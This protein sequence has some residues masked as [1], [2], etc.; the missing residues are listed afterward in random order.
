MTLKKLKLLIKIL[1]RLDFI[2]KFGLLSGLRKEEELRH[3]HM[4][5]DKLQ[6]QE[7]GGYDAV[8]LNIY[9]VHKKASLPYCL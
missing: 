1:C 4:F 2:V 5:K 3:M 8:L 7:K 6:T 9:G